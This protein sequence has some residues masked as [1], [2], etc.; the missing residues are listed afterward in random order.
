M[1]RTDDRGYVFLQ[2]RSDEMINSG[3][4]NI[5]PREV[6]DILATH[7]AV[8]EAVVLGMPDPRWG[9]AVTAVVRL[10][11]SVAVSSEE[12]IDFVRPRLGMRTPRR[13]EVWDSIP[14]TPYGKVDRVV[15]K[16]RLNGEEPS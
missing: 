3:G 11:G 8:S 16:S 9:D 13:L 14:R 1:A 15:L 5:A 12:L 4:Y 2:G 6:E 7:A 10:R